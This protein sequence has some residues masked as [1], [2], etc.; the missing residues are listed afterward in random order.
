MENSVGNAIEV[1]ANVLYLIEHAADDPTRVRLY[2]DLAKPA[3]EILVKQ[4][5]SE[6]SADRNR[7][8]R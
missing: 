2:T 4:A 5:T 3:V 6:I 1:L 7:K 8:E